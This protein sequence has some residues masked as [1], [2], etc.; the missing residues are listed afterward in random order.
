[1][2]RTKEQDKLL[3]ERLERRL[4]WFKEIMPYIKEGKIIEFGCG[5]GALLQVLSENFPNSFIVGLDI[6]D[7]M[8]KLVNSRNLKNVV[9]VRSQA[10]ERVFLEESFDTAIFVQVLH[11]IYSFAGEDKVA[12]AIKVASEVLKREGALIIRDTLKPKPRQVR[13]S[14]KNEKIREKF[15]RFVDEFKPRKIAYKAIGRDIFLDIT[16]ALEFITKHH[17]PDWEAEMKECHYFF[18]R[19]QYIDVLSNLGFNIK[20]MREFGLVKKPCRSFE[21]IWTSTSS[22][23]TAMW[24][25]SPKKLS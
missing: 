2:F 24:K 9:A 23:T 20:A 12:Q 16:D 18:G 13:L 4:D 10:Y 3:A 17:H 19:G 8:L 11:E 6:S 22:R 5:S 1:M 7:T 14:F 21:E 25:S 15:Y